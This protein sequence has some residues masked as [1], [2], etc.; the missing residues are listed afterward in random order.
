MEWF[1]DKPPTKGWGRWFFMLVAGTLI[2]VFAGS[3]VN[4][5]PVLAQENTDGSTSQEEDTSQQEDGD[6]ESESEEQTSEDLEDESFSSS[7]NIDNIGWLICGPVSWLANGMDLM[8]DYLLGFLQVR[9]L[10]VNNTNSAFYQAWNVMRAVANAVFIIAF[11]IIVYSQVSSFGVSS[12]GIKKMAPRLIVAA[13]LVNLSYFICVVLV[14]LSNIAGITVKDVFDNITKSLLQNGESNFTG[15]ISISSITQAFLTGGALT[16]AGVATVSGSTAAATPFFIP[17]LA[18]LFLSLLVA[19][20]VMAARQALIVI[21]VVISPLAF[22]AYLLPGTEKLFDKWKDTF[23]VMLV[24]FPAFSAVFG[25]ATLAGMIIMTNAQSIVIFILGFA[26]LLAPLAITPFIMKLG[27]GLLNRFAGIVNDPAKGMVDKSKEWA[28]N[29]SKVM[30]MNSYDRMAKNRE[31]WKNDEGGGGLG[32]RARRAWY[33]GGGYGAARRS[34]RY[35]DN[36]GRLLKDQAADADKRAENTY[37]DSSAY[38][39]HDLR[40]RHTADRSELLS[41]QASNRYDEMKGGKVPTDIAPTFSQKLPVAG[42]RITKAIE[43]HEQELTRQTQV[44]YEDVAIQSIRK[45]NN[46]R[47]LNQMF[48]E[49]MEANVDLQ[50][51]AAGIY[52]KASDGYR[53]GMDAALA[54]AIT[55]MRNDYGKSVE[56]GA[57]I[58]K[59][60]NL[61]SEQRQ[62]HA[63]GQTFTVKGRVFDSSNTF[64]REA[65][66]EEQIAVGTVEQVRQIIQESGGALSEFKTTISSSVAKSGVKGKAPFIGGRLIDEIAKGTITS[67]DALIGYIQ[68]WIA[69]GK[70]RDEDIAVT[71]PDGLKLLMQAARSSTAHMSSALK[72]KLAGGLLDLSTR[73][74][75]VMKNKDLNIHISKKAA[76]LMDKIRR[77]IFTP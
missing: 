50:K 27:G 66:I 6:A 30:A 74:D 24:F 47:Q 45:N 42:K 60:F 2:G 17:I 54:S 3:L 35:L 69:D 4:L 65:A 26:V 32:K 21:L 43:K 9:P 64:T 39:R 13:I 48:A 55:T 72:P 71:D 46:Q 36:R 40:Q 49:R 44:L 18:M 22:V 38:K 62:K 76:P 15:M 77:G 51:A 61:S 33:T 16:V 68:E 34:A 11:L 57:Q 28:K 23:L 29:K 10:E 19:L 58:I 25:G 8:Y 31:K 59:H 12:Y 56:E 37:H 63:L 14:D 73:T 67:E 41:Q 7:C 20:L 70:Y 52:G 5:T 53:Q 75:A 1:F